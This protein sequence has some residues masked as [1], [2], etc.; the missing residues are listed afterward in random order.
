MLITWNQ[1]E[2]R[3]DREIVEDLEPV[4]VLYSGCGSCELFEVILQRLTDSIVIDSQSKTVIGT[5]VRE[6]IGKQRYVRVARD[7]V[8]FLRSISAL[9]GR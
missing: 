1:P 5:A 4:L 6:A 8:C 9:S 2:R 7:S 3:S